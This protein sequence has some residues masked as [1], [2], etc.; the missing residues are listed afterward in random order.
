MMT[1]V[2]ELCDPLT[3]GLSKKRGKM[4]SQVIN[5]VQ[6]L[7][8][9]P[10]DP[11]E[12]IILKLKQY[13]RAVVVLKI[14]TSCLLDYSLKEARQSNEGREGPGR[15]HKRE[16]ETKI[17]VWAKRCFNS[18]SEIVGKESL[19]EGSVF[20]SSVLHLGIMTLIES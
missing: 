1:F 13:V 12:Y 3:V 11:K 10:K 20:Q 17:K 8:W 14:H 9:N 15:E 2:S 7:G 6:D 16:K 19:M 18:T 4:I 5:E